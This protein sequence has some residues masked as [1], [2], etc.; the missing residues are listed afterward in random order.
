MQ[1]RKAKT[2]KGRKLLQAREAKTEEG[3]RK[4]LFI[5]GNKTSEQIGDMMK[6]LYL[7]KKDNS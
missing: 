4:S 5:R 7:M 1:F 2:H 6:K 3:I